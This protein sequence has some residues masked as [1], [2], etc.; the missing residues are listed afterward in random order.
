MRTNNYYTLNEFLRTKHG[1]KILKLSIDGGF[2]CPNRDGRIS[3]KGCLFCSEHGSGDF[4][5]YDEGSITQQLQKASILLS[6]KWGTDK[7]YIAYFQSFTNTYAPI[8]ILRKKYEEALSYP[9]VVGLAIATR[10]DCLNDDVISLLSE[11]NQKTHL[12][13]ELGLQT[14]HEKTAQIINRGYSLDCFTKAVNTLHVHHIETVVHLILGLPGESK[15]DMLASASYISHLPLQGIKLHML[16]ILDNAP[17]NLYYKA[18]PFDILTQEEYTQIVGEILCLIPPNFVIHRLTGDG[19][20]KHLV[21]P[22]WTLQKKKVLNE[23]HKYI[24]SHHIYQGKSLN[25]Y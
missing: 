14:I 5:F 25:T 10:P 17:L 23:M 20:R 9:N 3:S 18:H 13:I 16:H 24:E 4:T 19:D 21:A 6:K 15:E 7:K 22:L 1:E 2:T 8:D 12:W 11:L